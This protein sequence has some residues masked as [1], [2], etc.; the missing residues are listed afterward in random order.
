LHQSTTW[1]YPGGG[2]IPTAKIK[3]ASVHGGA[4][5]AGGTSAG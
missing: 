4:D 3:C 5:I 1:S 2:V